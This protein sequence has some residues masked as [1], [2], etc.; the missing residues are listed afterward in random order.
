LTSIVEAALTWY[1]AGCSVIPIRADGTKK[2]T[3]EWAPFMVRRMERKRLS[4]WFVGHPDQGI[5]IICGAVSGG[6]EMLELEGRAASGDDISKILSECEARGVDELFQSLMLNGYAE[7]T[8]SGGLHFLYRISDHEVPGNT[9]VARRMATPEELADKPGDRFKVLSETRGEGG[10][11]VVAPSCGAVHS[12]GDSWSVAAGQLGVIPTISW[13]Q[14]CKLHEA[15]HAALDEMPP[16]VMPATR[17]ALSSLLPQ[18]SN[19]PGDDFNSRADWSDILLPNGWKI[20]K[21]SGGTTYWLRPGKDRSERGHSATTGHAADGDRLYVF[22]SATAFE[23]ETPYNKFAALAL[24]EYNGDFSAASRALRGMGYG[25]PATGGMAAPVTPPSELARADW[26]DKAIDTAAAQKVQGTEVAV[27]DPN[28]LHQWSRPFI[29][30]DALEFVEQSYAAGG[31]VYGQIYEDT[32]KYCGQLKKWFLFNGVTWE[33]DHKGA[34]EQGVV[35]MLLETGKRARADENTELAKW[36]RS[37]GRSSSPN[38]A[39]WARTDPRIAVVRNEFDRHRHV[40]AVGNG[41]L[42]LD[43]H[44]FSPTHDPKLLLTKQLYVNYDKDATA[45]TWEKLLKTLLPDPEIRAYLQRAAGHTL[46]GDAQER[47]LFLLHGAPGT[48]KSQVVKV[49]E[50]MFGDFAETANATT[51]NEH[52]KK[53]SITNDLNDLR[54]KRFVAVAE[55]D[56]DERLNEALIKRLTGGDTA[57]SRGLYQENSSWDVEFSLWMVTNFLPRLNSGDAAIWARV[58]PIKFDVLVKDQGPEVKKIGEKIFA[59]ESSGVLNWLLEGVRLYQEHGLE[60]LPQITEAVAGY[61]HDSD[62]VAQFI[63]TAAEEHVV[64]K[65]PQAQMPSRQLHTMYQD[66][67]GKNGIRWLG[68]RRFCQRMESLGFERKRTNTGAVW[69]GVGTGSYGMLGTMAMRQ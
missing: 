68:E 27:R 8:P 46:L 13:E 6:L 36:I 66:W 34:H 5:G 30:A 45:P 41:V 25:A 38:L 32:F 57:K 65:D 61:R 17:P 54:G 63:D 55:L 35:H 19:R 3:G 4:N 59:E 20:V 67:C 52:S 43:T 11:L 42:D 37:M 50:R 22:S 14:R 44:S 31:Q 9:K 1:D 39:R 58:K 24:L 18:S 21:Y 28:W 23:P 10:Y 29:P 69:L 60:D 16:P 26:A 40:I 15:I 56:E 49:L 2:P 62:T 64:I 51:F 7:W 53:A 33:E 48:G 47:A 12:T